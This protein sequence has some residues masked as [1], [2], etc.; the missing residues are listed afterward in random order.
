MS[1]DISDEVM[2]NV[3]Y[4]EGNS[5]D[6]EL[7]QRVMDISGD[8]FKLESANTLKD[9]IKLL[10]AN[11]YNC[12]LLDLHLPDG[13]E[14]YIVESIIKVKKGSIPIIVFTSVGAVDVKRYMELGVDDFCYKHNMKSV[15]EKIIRAVQ[16][17][18][19]RIKYKDNQVNECAHKLISKFNDIETKLNKLL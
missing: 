16:R 19:R 18:K 3:L 6:I 8:S 9:G 7:L 4:I 11:K 10:E 14:K 15:L 5:F 17:H 13:E 2:L 1:I 12:I